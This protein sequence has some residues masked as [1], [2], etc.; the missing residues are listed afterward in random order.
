MLHA[1][2]MAG[3]SGTRFWPESRA[4]HPKQLLDFHGGKT[5]IQATVARLGSLVPPE[6]VLIATSQALA[7]PIGEQLPKL[8]KQ[9]ILAEPC[10]RDTA[11]CI[12]LAA[13]HIAKHDADATMLVMPSDHVI[14][15][16]EQFQASLQFAAKL[17]DENPGRI[18]TFG[19]KPTYAAE[20]FGYIQRGKELM[21]SPHAAFQ[22]AQFK[23]KPKADVAEK[24]LA[25][26]Q[27]YWNA[28]I[29][30][31]KAKTIL[32]LIEK[33]EPAMF[34]CL[35]KIGDAIGRPDYAEVEAREF[36]AIQGKSIDYAVLERHDDVVVVEAPFTWDDV[37]SWQALA[38]LRG[39]D[40]EGNT[41]LARHVGVDTKGTIVRG[42]D[43]H[44]IATVGLEDIIVVHTPNAT[45]VAR[46]DREEDVRKIVEQLKKMEEGKE[47]L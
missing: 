32:A 11:A 17:I 26:G 6:R 10:R 2:V 18:V 7:Q 43:N 28:G 31:W 29:F 15:T 46:R 37:G 14:E 8:P 1:V 24:Y 3:G 5:M 30:V 25:S 40:A 41:I 21:K 23:E 39:N 9:A 36:A 27:Y 47:Y 12:G 19:I 42:P 16:A 35:K 45:L 20:S 22:V 38:R 34:A 4:A 33:Y 44:L 13:L